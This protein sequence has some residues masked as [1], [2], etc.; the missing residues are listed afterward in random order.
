M[1]LDLLETSSPVVE[2]V[3]LLTEK[4]RNAGQL[5][6]VDAAKGE[7]LLAQGA[8]VESVFVLQSGLIKLVY[9]TADGDE[10]IKSIIVDC[11]LFGPSSSDEG[12][13][14][15]YSA[16]AIEP[17]TLGRIPLGWVAQTLNRSPEMAAAYAGFV[18]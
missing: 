2:L 18:N 12:R 10:W 17:S 4:A 6:T 15:A 3:G 14:I 16:R 11:G 5:L 1:N 9:E 13:A 7:G 8:P